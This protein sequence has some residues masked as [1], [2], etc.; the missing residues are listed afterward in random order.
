M[1]TTRG[2]IDREAERSCGNDTRWMVDWIGRKCLHSGD[3]NVSVLILN[4]ATAKIP[5]GEMISSATEP[6]IE[7]RDE[8]GTLVAKLAV[9]QNDDELERQFVELIENDI[10]DI[11]RRARRD[12]AEDV[13]TDQLLALA[14]E[15]AARAKV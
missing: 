2:G 5:I 7:I 1:T 3:G 4:E 10:E 14:C 9:E 8:A 6:I 11:R 15:A 12:P 13:T